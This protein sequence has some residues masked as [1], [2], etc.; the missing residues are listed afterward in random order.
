M[1]YAT[2]AK[3]HQT[4]VEILKELGVPEAKFSITDTTILI[5][6]GCYVGRSLVCGQVRVVMLSGGERI[7]FYDQGGCLL[8]VICLG[9]SAAVQ[10]EAA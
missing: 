3:I 4:I 7:E 5:Q 2:Q 10:G 9:Q 8:R 1:D 6:D